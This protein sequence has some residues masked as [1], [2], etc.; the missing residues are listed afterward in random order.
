VLY[1]VLN[2]G[3][4]HATRSVPLIEALLKSGTIVE[5]TS[6]GAAL[7]YLKKRFPQLLAYELPDLE[8]KYSNRG[9]RAGLIRR[10]L[11]QSK[12][13]SRQRRFVDKLSTERKYSH[14]VSDNV[15]GAYSTKIPSALITHQLSLE[16]PFGKNQVNARLARWINRFSEVW[17]PDDASESI[18]GRLAKNRNVS[19]PKRHLGILT[20]FA[21]CI[22]GE[23]IYEIG[24]VLGGPEPQRSVL[25]KKLLKL[26]MS[27]SGNLI[28]FRGSENGET[29][30][31]TNLETH[32]MGD[33]IDM[34]EKLAA[35][36][37]VIGRAGFSTICDLLAT[38]SRAL[39]VPTP[40]QSEQEYLANR[41]SKLARFMT[42]KQEDLNEEV[43]QRLLNAQNEPPPGP[44]F[45]ETDS[46]VI[47]DFLKS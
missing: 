2:W 45:F 1:A 7:Q 39:L 33:G 5:I 9:A 43:I 31:R 25:E 44:A 20:R 10:G 24:I 32:S 19:I 36:K 47:R 38:K 40:G 13:N 30:N 21:A 6:S 4:G 35:C 3:L 29:E 17:I 12:I 27:F 18:A 16:L 42:C 23:K 26:T 22:P 8:V 14:I 11:I 34:A 37:L 41:M 28:L 15:Y 46:Q